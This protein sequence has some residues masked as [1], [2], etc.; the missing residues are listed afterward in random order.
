[1]EPIGCTD[2]MKSGLEASDD[3][4]TEDLHQMKTRLEDELHHLL[5]AQSA[6]HQE[7]SPCSIEELTSRTANLMQKFA[8]ESNTFS[9]NELLVKRIQF[10]KLLCA[11]I[12]N[13]DSDSNGHLQG[14]LKKTH[15]ATEI[16][17]IH[18]EICENQEKLEA[19]KLENLELRKENLS[20]MEQI[21]NW[22][23]LHNNVPAEVA[24]SR[25]YQKL[26]K[27]LEMRTMAVTINKS[28]IKHLILGMGVDWSED[29]EL[30][31][32]LLESSGPLQ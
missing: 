10:G 25:E 11:E 20:L 7:S 18:K 1:M 6:A 28:I 16:I 4:S 19:Q 3:I 22:K 23:D 27:D 5:V 13:R 9:R 30:C 32:L 29:P 17:R 15:A 24:S 14:I 21:K 2:G 26:K 12:F 8:V 31:Q